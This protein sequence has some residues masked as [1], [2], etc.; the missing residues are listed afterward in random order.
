MSSNNGTSFNLNIFQSSS[1]G[2]DG[3]SPSDQVDGLAPSASATDGAV[4]RASAEHKSGPGTW[5][6][7][8]RFNS[9][10]I[11]HAI[12]GSNQFEAEKESQSSSAMQVADPAQPAAAGGD[13][14]ADNSYRFD[15]IYSSQSSP[16]QEDEYLRSFENGTATPNGTTTDGSQQTHT[17]AIQDPGAL[18]EAESLLRAHMPD[19]HVSTTEPE[20]RAAETTQTDQDHIVTV[21]P[22]GGLF[23][24][25]LQGYNNQTQ[26]NNR[27]NEKKDEPLPPD[28]K[29]SAPS[30]RPSSRPSTPTRRKWY[31][32]SHQSTP[33]LDTVGQL[34]ESSSRLAA[35]SVKAGVPL[36]TPPVMKRP[37][38]PR[39]ASG[40]IKSLMGLKRENDAKITVHVAGILQRQKYILKMCLALMRYGAPSHRLEEYLSTTAKVLTMEC[41]FLYIPGC[42]II[43]FDDV[44]THTTEVKM[45]RASQGV[46]LG[47][48]KDVHL[49]YKEVLHD[50]I[51]LDEA[52]SRLEAILKAENRWPVWLCILMYGLASTAVSTFFSSRLI[53]MPV[54]FVLG[55]L[56]G[57]LQLV[58]APVSATYN[59]IFEVS[60]SILL[61]F[62]SRAVASVRGGNLF[63]F[64][65][66]TQSSIAMILPG[67]LVLS[68]ALELHSKAIV[69]GSIRMVYAIIYSLFLGYGITVGTA[70][71]GA[72]DPDAVSSTTCQNPLSKYWAFLLVPFYIFFLLFTVQ[73]KWKQMPVM[74]LIALAGYAVNFYTSQK[75][76]AS[77]PIAYTFG[78]FV[79]GILANL[80]SRVR[81]DVAA[82]ILLPAVY[83]QV[84]GSLASSGAITVGLKTATLLTQTNGTDSTDSTQLNALAFNF[85]A[86][87]I[88][89]AIGITV[90][91]FGSALLIYPLGKRRSGLWTL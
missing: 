42:M 20:G 32:N 77:A 12:F 16:T 73:A 41:Q 66:L 60:A 83:V 17:D 44:L 39:T 63:C 48:L 8:V 72:V 50:I 40:R 59:T 35:Q 9:D 52:L 31:K 43:S 65:A 36:N 68:S 11:K 4:P 78:A 88:Q 25:I 57:V 49:I 22:R 21:N 51:G 62:L 14:S 71:Y 75:F 86:S 69:P 70:L 64:S 45:V 67:W 46:N 85:A 26:H 76:A 84:P 91:L 79:I 47:K 23:F 56:L 33:S 10:A 5:G 54:I 61:T 90:G 2:S 28:G 80:Y 37:Q 55:S 38:A 58:I 7:R 81:H 89:I 15:E 27:K 82:A 74:I 18:R 53:D 6:R 19:I 30:S 3:D 1:S 29:S 13:S 87:M 34:L 24:H